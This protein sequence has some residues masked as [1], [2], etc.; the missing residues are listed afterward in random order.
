MK[1]INCLYPIYCDNYRVSHTFLSLFRVWQ[2]ADLNA[3]MFVPNCNP[4]YRPQNLTEVVPKY[5]KWWYYK[6]PNA[7][8]KATEKVFIE[9]MKK[10]SSDMAY[11][12]PGT[13]LSV[14]QKIKKLGKPIITERIN[15]Y[16][17]KAKRI[18][19][20]A[21]LN[22]GN[23][24]QHS[25]TETMIENEDLQMKLSDFIFCPSPEVIHSFLESGVPE[26]KIISTSYGWEP[27]RFTQLSTPKITRNP[28]KFIFVGRVCVRKGVHLLLQ[29]W[30]KANI[31]GKL[32][33]AGQL[34]P[35][36]AE[37]YQSI[38]SRPDVV[39]LGFKNDISS[40]FQEADV[41]VLPSLEEGSPL[42]TYEA[43]AH[44]LA[45]LTSPM[46]GGGVIRDGQDGL[47]INPYHEQ[48]LVHALQ[49]LANSP[50]LRQTLGISAQQRSQDF[51]WNKVANRR[52]IDL[53]EKLKTFS[54]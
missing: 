22:L 2:T 14:Y 34:E 46:G 12:W 36:I 44:G 16:T 6:F 32:L 18:L 53:L 9:E 7:P 25:I 3:Q 39:C 35:L 38:L 48:A 1:K 51:T 42:V 8:R 50:E 10:P 17:G 33:I 47:I 29:S 11:L 21:Y 30:E 37:R 40:V 31:D 27:K 4:I 43:M 26:S 54:S 20:E 19:D 45:I 41:F 49:T 52:K 23:I 28:V 13:S 24:P 15:C 5:L